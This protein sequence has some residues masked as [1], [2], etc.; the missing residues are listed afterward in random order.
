MD[1]VE[2]QEYSNAIA[3]VGMDCRFPG[4]NGADAFW[5]NLRDGVESISFFSEQELLAS[6]ID[7]ATFSQ[8]N[9][10]PARGVLDDIDRFDA[11][12][13][14]FTQ[15]EAEILDPQQRLFLECAWAALEHA[16]YA[17]EHFE[18]SI[19]VYA[20]ASS[21][22]YVF[23]PYANRDLMRRLGDFALALA[24]GREYLATRL[25]YKLNLQGPSVT[26]QTAC[27]T[28]L[29]AVH[30][31]CQSLLSYQC[32]LALA[33][34]VSIT[35]PHRAGYL[36]QNGGITS[37]DGHCRAFDADAQGFVGGNGVGVVVLKR[38]ADALAEGDSIYAVIKGAA[39]N[40]DGAQKVGF[41]A[42]S[43]DGQAAVI[44]LAQALANVEP[45]SISY[46]ETHGTGTAL[47]DTIE[48]AALTEVFRAG[49]DRRGFCAIG[50]VKPNIGHLDAASG[51]AGLI[52]TVLALIHHQIPPSLHFKRPNEK[53]D[54]AGSPFYVNTQLRPWPATNGPRRAGVS[55]FGIGGT[56]AHVILEEA[57]EPAVSEPSR[58]W[59]VLLLS[60]KS[61][62]ALETAT[63]NL[64]ADL[65]QHPERNFADVAYTLQV[66]RRA[67]A[68]RR[69]LVCRDLA[70]AV[71]AL[72]A[73]DAR[74]TITGVQERRERPVAF[75]FPG[76]GMQHLN[77][78][79]DIYQ[80]EPL[81]REQVDRC[82][83]ILEPFLGL[84]LRE[85]LY[86][87]GD[88][89][90]RGQ[91]D[92][93][94]PT[95]DSVTLSGE[96]DQ[97]QYA[98]P[99][100]FTVEYALARMWMG[101]GICPARMLGHSI[102]ELVAACLAGVMSLEDA[103][104][105]VLVRGRLMQ[106]LPPGSMLAVPL[107]E[108]SVRP[109]L[110]ERL[111]LAAVNEPSRCVVSGPPDA[112]DALRGLLAER[113]VD[114]RY[115]Q[116][117]HAFH[118]SMLEPIVGAFAEQVSKIALH[119]PQIPFLSNVTGTW[120][121]ATEA[122]SPR[123]WAA[124]LRQTVRF[125]AGL[126]LLFAEPDQ[127]LLEVGPGQ[128]LSALAKRQ[129]HK[130]PEQI[131]LASLPHPRDSQSDAQQVIETLGRLWLAGAAIDWSGV[132]A[133]ERRRRVA[134]PT[135]PFER[136]RYWIAADQG[137]DR[138][139][140]DSSQNQTDRDGTATPAEA[141]A[142]PGEP[143][144]AARSA[145]AGQALPRSPRGQV[146]LARIQSLASY[147]IGVTAEA[148]DPR[149]TWLDLGFDSLLL[150]QLNQTIQDEFD[151]KITLVELMESYTTVEAL[152]AYID[153][154][155]PEVVPP[156]APDAAPFPSANSGIGF[157]PGL[158]MQPPPPVIG[159]VDWP[160][161]HPALADPA[162]SATTALE[163]VIAQ[164]LQVMSQQLAM[165]QNQGVAH[166][167][168]PVHPAPAPARQPAARPDQ[169]RD[170][171]PAA[172]A[173]TVP[174]SESFVPYRP[175]DLTASG[176]TAQQK[177]YLD[178][179]VERYTDRTR[180][181]K[182]LTQQHRLPLADSRA[183][184]NFRL[185]WKELVYPI[186]MQRSLGSKLWD[187]DNN[188]YIDITMG[189]GV[190]LFGHS[191][192]FMI[193]AIEAQLREGMHLG[194]QSALAGEVAA[195]LCALTGVERA[196]F[197]N[198]GT[199]AVMG[200]LR[201]ARTVTRRS[202]IAYFAG[203]YHGWSDSTM[204]RPTAAGGPGRA[205]PVA[206]GV[207]IGAIAD[208]LVLEY[209]SPEL[210]AILA[211]H[212]HELAAVLVEPVQSRRPDLQPRAFLHEL[213]RLTAQAGTALIFDEVLCGFRVHPGGCQSWF[214]IRADIVTYGK[215]L[216]GGL[217]IGVIAGQAAWLD[218]FDGGM[219]RYGDASYPTAEKTLFAGTYFKNPLTLAVTRA[220][221]DQLEAQGPELQ[222]RISQRTTELAETLNTY[223][224]QR[225]V[226]LRMVFFSS[227]FRFQFL[228]DAQIADLFF[229]HLIDKGV[230]V[231]EGGNCFL[232]TAHTDADL[233]HIIKAVKQSVEDLCAGG[234]LVPAP[235]S[236]PPP[237]MA[238]SRGG[239][240]QAPATPTA[241]TGAAPAVAANA[242]S[243]DGPPARIPL[244]EA[245][246]GLWLLAQMGPQVSAAYNETVRLHLSGPLDD[247]ALRVAFHAVIG[248]HEALRTTFSPD[249]AYQLIAPTL[250]F[251]LP[252]IDVSMH[253]PTQRA[254]RVAEFLAQER[255]QPFDLVNGP[256]LR[257][258][259]LKLE[260]RQHLLVLT[261]HHIVTDSRSLGIVFQELHTLYLAAARGE[262]AQLPAPLQFRDYVAWLDQQLQGPNGQAAEDYWLR[263]FAGELPPLEL[264]T[265]RPRPPQQ[266]YN[267]RL[268][269]TLIEPAIAA[270]IRE[271]AN[272]SGTT[273]FMLLLAGFNLL[274]HRLTGQPD[275]VIG[276]PAAGQ[277]HMGD[278]VLAGYCINLVPLHSTIAGDP[279]F[280]AY[281]TALRRILL[282]SYTYQSY[283]FA[284][285]LSK[286]KLP[287]DPSRAPLV[288]ATMTLERGGG[289]S[290]LFGLKTE[291]TSEPSRAA[292]FDISLRVVDL[293]EGLGLEWEYNANIFDVR[294]IRRWM[295]HFQTLLSGISA[296]PA[297]RILQLPLLTAAQQHELLITHN[298]TQV[299]YT[300][301]LCLHQLVER[302]AA[303]TPDAC[304][305]IFP[306]S[307]S[308]PGESLQLTYHELDRRANQLAHHLRA[309]GV[310]PDRAVGVSIERSPEL[311]ISLLAIL[312]AGGAYLPLDPSYPAE[313]L[314]FMLAEA[315]PAVLLTRQEPR[316]KNQEPDS[317]VEG[318]RFSVLG[319]VVDLVG[320]WPTIARA[321]ETSPHSGVRPD[322]L[323][324]IIY[325][326]GSTGRPKGAMNTHRGI[327][328]RLLWMQDTYR[329]SMEDRVVQKTPFS[330]DV[331]VWEFFWPL[332]SGAG[333]V[334]AQPGGHQD[335]AYLAD[336]I[337]EQ[338]ITTI[339]FVPSMLD[340]F[341]AE[342]SASECISLR[343]V[344]CSGEALPFRLHERFFACM[345]A[346]LHNL[347]GPTEAAVDV[348]A[349]ECRRANDQWAVPIGTPVANTQIYLLD[350]QMQPVPPGV[351]GELYIGGV[352]LARGYLGRPDLTAE[353]F[354]P[355]PFTEERLEIR[356]WRLSG[357]QSPISNLQS[358]ISNRL[359]KTGDRA[360]YR[361]DGAIE[362]LG[363]LDDQ[364]K[365][366]GFR[367]ELGEIEATL[368]RHPA[369]R[370]AAVLVHADAAGAARLVAYIV[371]I[372]E[373]RTKN[374]EQKSE[375][376]ASQ[377]SIL[378]SQLLAALRSFL[379]TYLPE[380]MVPAIFVA[381]DA[382]PLTPSGKLDRRALPAPDTGHLSS[383]QAYVAPSTPVEVEL[384]ALWSELLGI[385]RIGGH[386]DFFELGGHS[387]L[388][389]RLAIRI[390]AAF[391]VDLPLRLLFDAPTIVAQSVLIANRQIAQLEPGEITQ[392]LED[393]VG[394]SPEEIKRLLEQE[395]Q[396]V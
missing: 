171:P 284:R 175:I 135:Y 386:D 132:Y 169:R 149:A 55:S 199:E 359:Y 196:N 261:I 212:M 70:D 335:S 1:S 21:S 226:P 185:L 321:P 345:S 95:E 315:Q 286:L 17:P 213:R 256:L 327:V 223:F 105:L 33:G 154:V 150:I 288:N 373:Q 227:L 3:I 260:E 285:L 49:T 18:G 134:L 22:T 90:T 87:A 114:T 81:F 267:G 346:G 375:K 92:K 60:A 126:D 88:K 79:V 348:T 274:L 85:L 54:F 121:T 184:A 108:P 122:T 71:A 276:F 326:S 394:L 384:A 342:P 320:D 168:L 147:F 318:S 272:R 26:V 151:I 195:K 269:T 254:E 24:N 119:P 370:E 162:E 35:V 174:R 96:L 47:G 44:V 349:W 34:G 8:P 192:P 362:Y 282:E 377:F 2:T 29:V 97:T 112:I 209:G 170:S 266:T 338:Q 76:Q 208:T 15:R 255:A 292:K 128:T 391:H 360:R 350:R 277:V 4:A 389:M 232:S 329:L 191:P 37:P 366:R 10:V 179:F 217:P 306:S 123:Y 163:R 248:R 75:L 144:A 137:E 58:P 333:L 325:T 127:I 194:P 219:W 331:S 393:L 80:H 155:S 160:V 118:S 368:R 73:L 198:S 46:I 304:V 101:W 390:R 215:I 336:L 86:P 355:N 323:A 78:A 262:T 301:A 363:R 176:L 376:E 271:R 93:V 330:F 313:R 59:Q 104:W 125:A 41:T 133:H 148:V 280:L 372:E 216:G 339:H 293:G 369:V 214:G 341:L 352:Q 189:F 332:I 308:E 316:T 43:E 354:V 74:R 211:A 388:M 172:A 236:A 290:D 11:G 110:G 275:I 307:I 265:D 152:V 30:Q 166:G 206:P 83:E 225:G 177:D 305:L 234:F 270:A 100:L 383:A 143:G 145:A 204:A 139:M 165:L 242:E 295:E 324:Y 146:L 347:Y 264:P 69:M 31:A 23:N 183:T 257:A 106:A 201:L 205:I 387:L 153:Q 200:A 246:Q 241:D 239:M 299:D 278:K 237:D 207:P 224:I 245:Q 218:A 19:G 64:L 210:L 94:T 188:E 243:L 296:N 180:E 113:G 42:P 258:H 116:T 62:T 129:P 268:C 357:A 136:K 63:G 156:S 140:P 48:I 289:S 138:S 365:L 259:L 381:L 7:P 161:V 312:K 240:P 91:G 27:S 51:V 53:I 294:T 141:P 395:S 124:H 337:V 303:R 65:K 84:D 328:N 45:D 107:P 253:V 77:M 244:T 380:Y 298:A 36:Y 202:K 251:D 279:P 115:L 197:C 263:Q 317:P 222:E 283:P 228:R 379:Q 353:R 178:R 173:A 193:N 361:S 235:G 40:N 358:P 131:V 310:G 233:T 385:A 378:N 229:Y 281:L 99:A 356:D 252:L 103:L 98:Q 13:F 230:Y 68:H 231:W 52:K 287:R 273:L 367:I 28:S 82:A 314:A 32:D 89:L 20:G 382:L 130:A 250:T 249:G 164:Q 167:P 309:L 66:G 9:Y 120:I 247:R 6:G 117:S 111:S 61:Q 319:S 12:L 186:I 322:N 182:R 364:V 56:N 16:G 374:Q 396:A 238:G 302:Q 14:D 190:H 181:T 187:A 221:L 109:L 57:P 157:R 72:E 50:S 25:S 158:G 291:E 220:I 38:L 371:P 392:L 351:P 297:V 142:R 340:I 39:I 67:L 343:R 203:S 5:R 159:V 311:V 102:G 300:T 344:I 334:L